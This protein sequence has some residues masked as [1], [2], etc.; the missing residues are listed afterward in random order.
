MR[1]V[2]RSLR[3]ISMTVIML[4]LAGIT[5]LVVGRMERTVEARGEVRIERFQVVRPQV[6]GMIARVFAQPGD[7]VRPG[8]VLLQLEDHELRSDLASIRDEIDQSES[9]L[10]N[11]LLEREIFV[12]SIHPHEAEEQLAAIREGSLETDLRDSR[13][14]E[15]EIQRQAAEARLRRS[16]EL[17]RLGLLS[18]DKL[19]EAVHEALAAAER[20]QQSLIERKLGEN[21]LSSLHN[22]RELVR[23]QQTQ[24]LQKLGAEIQDLRKDI[25]G[26]MTRRSQLQALA[27]RHV[28]RA[29][30]AGVVVAPTPNELLGR[31]VAAGDPLLNVADTK[32]IVFVGQV[33]E[34]AIFRVRS[35]QSAY[36]EIAGLPKDRFDVFSGQVRTVA[37]EPA[38]S[39]A[40]PARAFYPVRIWLQEP[41]IHAEEGRF[42]LR[43]GMQGKARIA[44]R[45]DVPM[46]E[47]IYDVL[48]GRRPERMD[49]T[50]S[51]PIARA[52]M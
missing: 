22:R 36:V 28:L 27:E 12:R 52:T 29:G 10:K 3:G 7:H 1:L 11:L 5:L 4:L 30:I 38:Q 24:A 33:P 13:A 31:R 9:G 19:Q 25:H 49:Q 35:G 37:P 23:S 2:V 16:T 40:E 46:L 34:E 51:P 20:H 8:Q 39:S 41:W 6:S 50:K 14:K 43:T 15:L 18:K 48:V 17:E 32:S 47:V 45:R 44:Y 42:Y 21:R 26:L